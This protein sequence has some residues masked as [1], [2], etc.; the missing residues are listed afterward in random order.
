MRYIRRFRL[1]K[2]GTSQQRLMGSVHLTAMYTNKM[3]IIFFVFAAVQI[4]HCSAQS[5]G[6]TT[7]P[8]I[9]LVVNATIAQVNNEPSVGNASV[10]TRCE[11]V[12]SIPIG[13]RFIL[14]NIIV[15]VLGAETL[16]CTSQV[17]L[18]V[19][20]VLSVEVQ[21]RNTNVTTPAMTTSTSAATTPGTSATTPDTSAT[22]PD[23]SATTPTTSATTPT[24]SA[25][26]PTTSATTQTTTVTTPT[27]TLTKTTTTTTR[28]RGSS[29]SSSENSDSSE[30]CR[31]RG[32]RGNRYCR[33]RYGRSRGNRRR[34]PFRRQQRSLSASQMKLNQ[35][36]PHGAYETEENGR[37]EIHV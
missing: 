3:K 12:N 7:L 1:Y 22:T 29:S 20:Q 27:T 24:T 9:G 26:T 31:R 17:L 4:L 36:N 5:C 30:K 14:V 34:W 2:C 10:V 32:G 23:T 37:S 6:D 33:R 18:E 16:T 8:Q 21:C 28:K 35:Y 25:T 11:F 15:D 13:E 19:N